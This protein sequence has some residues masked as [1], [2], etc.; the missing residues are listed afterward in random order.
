MIVSAVNPLPS[1]YNNVCFVLTHDSDFEKWHT[2]AQNELSSI[3]QNHHLPEPIM[4]RQTNAFGINLDKNEPFVFDKIKENIM[5]LFIER[6]NDFYLGETI[7]P[8]GQ[9]APN[10]IFALKSLTRNEVWSNKYITII[11][12]DLDFSI[13]TPTPVT[14][15][16]NG[17]EVENGTTFGKNVENIITGL[18]LQEDTM[19][20]KVFS[21]EDYRE[22]LSLIRT[23]GNYVFYHSDSF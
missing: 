22:I 12:K 1:Q 13:T 21:D 5:K 16:H 15:F 10:N 11:G 2:Q 6:N 14:F 17:K 9:N 19:N 7:I 23:E 3:Y 8:Y 18:F 20:D 4:V